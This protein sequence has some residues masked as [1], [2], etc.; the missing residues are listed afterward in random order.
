M[1]TGTLPLLTGDLVIERPATQLAAICQRL[2]ALWR[3]ACDEVSHTCLP[4]VI[5]EPDLP[6]EVTV[7]L[8]GRTTTLPNIEAQLL[9]PTKLQP[10]KQRRNCGPAA[11]SCALTVVVEVAFVSY[12]V[13]IVV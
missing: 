12:A 3:Q 11:V 7:R 9:L 1:V 8:D 5:L 10:G 2:P 4:R 6:A 13:A